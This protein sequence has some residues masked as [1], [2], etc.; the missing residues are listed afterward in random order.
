[1]CSLMDIPIDLNKGNQHCVEPWNEDKLRRFKQMSDLS[2]I[3]VIIIDEIST[4]NPYMIGYQN[5]R[6]QTAYVSTA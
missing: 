5:A 3:W 6:L 4:V 2:K 1:M